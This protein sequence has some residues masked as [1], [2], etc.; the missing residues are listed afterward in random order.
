[1]VLT[2]NGGNMDDGTDAEIESVDTLTFT[3]GSIYKLT[4]SD[5]LPITS[6][7]DLLFDSKV[8]ITGSTGILYMNSNSTIT[9][10]EDV[11]SSGEISIT[12][13]KLTMK[14]IEFYFLTIFF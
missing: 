1:M 3:A 11:T 2:Y 13:T 14:S 9:F 6:Q 4:G 12:V 10:N 7:G 8:D 5:P